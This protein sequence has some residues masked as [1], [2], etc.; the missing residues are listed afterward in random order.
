MSD[1]A[2]S[3]EYGELWLEVVAAVEYLGATH[4][5]GLSVWDALAE[6]VRLWEEDMS[7][8]GDRGRERCSLPWNDPDPLRTALESLLRVTSPAGTPDGRGLPAVMD[9]ALCFWLD[10]MATA[11]NDDQCF[12]RRE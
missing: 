4:R 11:F 9:A 12:A 7:S 5:P 10:A 8:Q 2:R 1:E 6:A 3:V